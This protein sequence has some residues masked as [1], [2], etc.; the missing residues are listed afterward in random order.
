MSVRRLNGVRMRPQVWK[1]LS[2]GDTLSFGGTVDVQRKSRS[3][4]NPFVYVVGIE[5]KVDEVRHNS[6]SAVCDRQNENSASRVN[7][8][9]KVRSPFHLPGFVCKDGRCCSCHIRFSQ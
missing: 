3:V 4:R 1:S 2:D 9:A 7:S 6:S 8:A 5:G